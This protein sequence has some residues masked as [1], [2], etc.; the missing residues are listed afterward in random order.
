MLSVQ[1]IRHVTRADRL[2][3]IKTREDTFAPESSD[4]EEGGLGR[5][6]YA[7]DTI[8]RQ[9]NKTSKDS[10]REEDH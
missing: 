1:A 10:G 4:T 7:K 9:A 2:H 3:N 8:V 6:P 5:L